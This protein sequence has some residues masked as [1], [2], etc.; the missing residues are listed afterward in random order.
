M[1]PLRAADSAV[2]A[3]RRPARQGEGSQRVG[4]TDESG[5]VSASRER[6]EGTEEQQILGVGA[7]LRVGGQS[8]RGFDDDGGREVEVVVGGD[9]VAVL[10]DG[11][12]LSE[13]VEGASAVQ[14]GVDDG[15]GFDAR[16]ELRGRLA[17]A[18]GDGAD[19]TVFG[20]EQGDDAVASPSLWVRRTIASSR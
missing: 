19:L 12:D 7:V 10:G 11:G 6:V 8:L 15:E 1:R 14:L 20:S 2:E 16:T 4:G 18:L 3:G 9:G 17:Y 5:V 13:G